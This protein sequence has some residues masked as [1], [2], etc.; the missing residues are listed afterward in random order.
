M[1][2]TT[3]SFLKKLMEPGVDP[4]KVSFFMPDHNGPC[5]FGQ[6]NKFQRIVFNKL[7]FKDAQIISPSNT[8]AYEDISGGQG[9]KFRYAAWKG[10][11]AVDLLR[12]LKQERIP[13]ELVPGSTEKVYR[14]VLAAVIISIENGAKDLA[15][16]L[17]REAKRFNEI[18]VHNGKRKPVIPVVGEIFMRDNP[19]CS[20]HLV[21]KLEQYGA[22]TVIAP[23]SEWLSYSTYRYTRDSRWKGDYKGIL[24]SKIQHYAQNFSARKLQQSVHGLY[25]HDREIELHEMLESCGPYIHMHYD[26]DPALNLGSS[27]AL[28]KTGISGI[29]NILPFT[30]MPGTVVTALADR[31]KRDH[32]NIPYVSIA[33][34]GQ[35]DTAIDLRLQ[36]FMHQAREFAKSKGYDSPVKW[37][38][39]K[40]MTKI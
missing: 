3:G 17:H 4:K 23:F 29:A 20:G 30:C 24:K 31:F 27:V 14:E 2:C 36:A 10:F 39:A 38:I 12:K 34:D 21:Q 40:E 1:I 26:G 8:T 32:D 6:Y 25:D 13:Y 18:A 19:F 33:Y 7:G 22:E 11:V 28:F 35:E 5:R 9:T 15:D 37:A 16:V